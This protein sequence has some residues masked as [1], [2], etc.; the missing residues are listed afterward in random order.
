MSRSHIKWS[1]STYTFRFAKHFQHISVDCVLKC[2]QNDLLL[3]SWVKDTQI[4]AFMLK[5]TRIS[6][7]DKTCYL[8]CLKLLFLWSSVTL[9]IRSR[10]MV[11]LYY[12]GSID[13]IYDY[14]S[15][16][17]KSNTSWKKE[18]F[19]PNKFCKGKLKF[20]L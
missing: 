19:A 14:Q 15:I 17:C 1:I 2:N 11:A 4:H 9:K 20:E 3:L 18:T 12:G 8:I 6:N 7:D 10:S 13:S 5:R 16:N